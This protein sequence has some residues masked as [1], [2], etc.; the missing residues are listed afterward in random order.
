MN[1][2]EASTAAGKAEQEAAYRE[3]AVLLRETGILP[4]W[5]EA[6]ETDILLRE[7]AVPVPPEIQVLQGSLPEIHIVEEQTDIEKTVTTKEE[8][9]IQKEIRVQHYG[10]V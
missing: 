5:E 3:S 8:V 7:E 10:L 2:N 9:P 6:A 4:L 1:L